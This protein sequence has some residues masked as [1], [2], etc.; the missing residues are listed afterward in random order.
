MSLELDFNHVIELRLRHANATLNVIP[1]SHMNHFML[2][3]PNCQKCYVEHGTKWAP[4]QDLLRDKVYSGTFDY[5]Y[6]MHSGEATIE[7]R[8][9][10]TAVCF[11][12]QDHACA[13]EYSVFSIQKAD[14][15]FYSLGDGYLGLNPA[16]LDSMTRAGW[17][18]KPMFGVHTKMTESTEDP[19]QIRFGGE[20]K[21]LFANDSSQLWLKTVNS[22]T[23]EMDLTEVDFH[24]D[25][26]IK[27][28]KAIINPGYPFIGVPKAH[29]ET[30]KKDVI[31]AYPDEAI[32][33][34]H[35]DWC[36]FMTPC[37]KLKK[38]MPDLTFTFKNTDGAKKTL[39]VPAESFLMPL[40]DPTTGI[41]QC[42]VGVIGQIYSSTE[43]WILGESFMQNFYVTFDATSS[44]EPKVGIAF[45]QSSVVV[46]E[47]GSSSVVVVIVIL[48]VTALLLVGAFFG[49]RFLYKRKQAQKLEKAKTYFESLK[50]DKTDEVEEKDVA[51]EDPNS[52]C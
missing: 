21:D 31:E 36:Y 42:H 8:L 23:W 51:T 38:V 52:F 18:S 29:F 45:S 22:T 5:F 19:S 37:D 15:W 34:D 14:P 24:G 32:S 43:N 10:D 4:D 35:V 16:A 28:S 41:D 17:I 11:N 30:F 48:V 13:H 3:H 20:N 26:I 12:T 6:N 2:A 40:T 27:N 25:D 47:S 50:T 49:F 44:A 7:G 1:D 9:W 46:S 33:C 39:R